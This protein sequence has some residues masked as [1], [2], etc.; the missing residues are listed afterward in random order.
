MAGRMAAIGERALVQ[1][2]AL[3]GVVVTVA[4]EAATVRD[5]WNT[6]APEVSVVV[7]TAAAAAAIGDVTTAPGRL[8]VVQP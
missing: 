4:E 3:A 1:G 8:V 7:L 6:L 5:A 2:Y